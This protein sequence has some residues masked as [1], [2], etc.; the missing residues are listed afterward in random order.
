MYSTILFIVDTSLSGFF[1][2]GERQTSA[3]E[4]YACTVSSGTRPV[5]S[6]TSSRPRRLARA[7]NSSKASPLPMKIACKSSRP[8]VAQVGEGAQRVV[9]AV[10][11]AHHAEVAGE[12][13]LAALERA[14]RARTGTKRVRSGALRTTNTWS[15]GIPPR[16]IATWR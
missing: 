13:A 5:N 6:T 12:E 7:T 9:D 14:G 3:V 4:R 16:V 10:L 1:G 11:R 15:G 2:S 8:L